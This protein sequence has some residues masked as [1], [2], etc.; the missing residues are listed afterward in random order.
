[1]ADFPCDLA[2]GFD[3]QQPPKNTQAHIALIVERWQADQAAAGSCRIIPIVHSSAKELPTLCA[4]VAAKTSVPILA[5][6]ERR[7]GESILGKL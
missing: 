3:E 2:F 1:L 4:A 5:V 7:L 6:P